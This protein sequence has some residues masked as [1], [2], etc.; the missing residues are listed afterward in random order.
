MKKPMVWLLAVL[1]LGGLASAQTL[2][3]VLAKNYQARG[4]LDKLQAVAAVKMSGKMVI[5][6]QG[7]EM[8]MVLWQKKPNRMRVE[9]TFQDKKII[10]AY[11]GRKAWWIM[12][13][14]SEAAQEMA[15]EQAK[16]LAEQADFE[17]PLV[18]FKEKGYK[19]ELQG[20]EDMA[21]TPVFKLKLTKA[22]G[23]EIYFYLDADSGI[24]LKSTLTLKS[25]EAETLNEILYD[26]YKP[27]DG[28]LMPF[29][30]ENKV[31]GK[32][33]VQMT[34]ESIEI[35]PV[36]SDGLFTMPQNKAEVKTEEPKQK[37]QAERTPKKTSGRSAAGK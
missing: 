34:M 8:P 23:R 2:D 30:V 15:P 37:T 14:K 22:G 31:N 13:F 6:A 36:I 29:S 3:E 21:G 1:F 16:L 20:R 12:P 33:Q 27:V 10:Q 28:L 4:G 11:D 24:E 18:V 7:L 17:N 5:P 26:D 9:T 35:N 25:G 19:L 32:T